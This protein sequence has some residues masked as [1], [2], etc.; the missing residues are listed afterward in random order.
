MP[1]MRLFIYWPFAI[2]KYKIITLLF[3]ILKDLW[4]K[5]MLKRM[6]SCLWQVRNLNRNWIRLILIV[7]RILK[8]RSL[9]K[10][11]KKSGWI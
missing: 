7:E 8:S 11:R 6:R 9:K 2:I 5:K 1:I 4:Q 10:A 3:S